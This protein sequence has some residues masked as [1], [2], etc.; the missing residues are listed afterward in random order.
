M[1]NNNLRRQNG[2]KSTDGTTLCSARGRKVLGPQITSL[3]EQLDAHTLTRKD[4]ISFN[5]LG[6]SAAGEGGA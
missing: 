5:L 2:I 4:D 3:K 1:C 6:V